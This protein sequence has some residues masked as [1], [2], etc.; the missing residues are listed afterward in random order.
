MRAMGAL[1]DEI[2]EA[3]N[4]KCHPGDLEEEWENLRALEQL[5]AKSLSRE[6]LQKLSNKFS[7]QPVR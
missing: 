3:C 4:L 7:K 5:Q 1:E 6:E 2:A